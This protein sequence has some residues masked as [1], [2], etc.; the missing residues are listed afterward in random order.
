MYT[1]GNPKTNASSPSAAASSIDTVLGSGFVATRDHLSLPTGTSPEPR[2]GTGDA[3]SPDRGDP[4]SPTR[5]QSVIRSRRRAEVTPTR[6]L[7]GRFGSQFLRLN[8]DQTPAKRPQNAP[9]PPKA[10][11]RP[12]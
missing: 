9:K 7:P 11:F 6:L 1:N 5:A 2:R 12:Q 8:R 10:G 4:S 3:G